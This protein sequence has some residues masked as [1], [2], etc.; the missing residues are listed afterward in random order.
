MAQFY[1]E[2]KD[3][4]ESRNIELEEIHDR[5]KINIKYLEAIEKGN[6]E[7]LPVPYLRLFLRA[8]AD[9]I[10]GDSSRALEQLDSFLGTTRTPAQTIQVPKND[11]LID[12]Q[13]KQ[14]IDR[15]SFFT[16]DKKLRED[17]IKGAILLIIFIFSIMVF[18]KIFN[19][20]SSAVMTS[21][22]LVIQQNISTIT[23]SE[24]IKNYIQLNSR[25]QILNVSPP[26]FV[27]LITRKETAF[28]FKNDTLPTITKYLQ[29]N[30]EYDLDAF[31]T[32]SDILFSST[33]GLTIFINGVQLQNVSNYNA[34][35]RLTIKPNPPTLVIQRF[36]SLR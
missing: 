36:K 20:D 11:E 6:F 31:V 14:G 26:F 22:G 8:Y 15:D 33:D 7:I 9:E 27:K 29:A 12:E 24:L 10:G 16:S 21:D 19:S 13:E 18:R 1:I 3:L 5:T 28:S 30:F 32:K 2:L 25:E 34:P 17:L 4:R 23:E 35:L